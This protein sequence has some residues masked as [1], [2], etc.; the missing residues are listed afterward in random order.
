MF[1]KIYN[2]I[3]KTVFSNEYNAKKIGVTMGANCRILG[4][5]DF[6]S[7]PYLIKLGSRVSITNSS[8]ITH[9][10]GVWVFREEYPE[11]D[12]IKPI[13]V[14]DNVFIGT[15]SVILPGVTIGSNVVVGACSVI[16]KN[17]PS[18][19]VAAGIP[20]RVIKTIEEYKENVLKYSIDTKKL[21]A[22]QKKS[23]LSEMFK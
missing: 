13:I 17:I 14:G 8:F 4:R 19:S 1:K 16:T 21:N 11:I 22:S 6:G 3:N 10:G 2:F 9:D 20:A 18:N 12:L 7:E 15:N 5:V 23:I